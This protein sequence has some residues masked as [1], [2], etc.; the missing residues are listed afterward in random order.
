MSL[1]VADMV[2]V[3]AAMAGCN[4]TPP[5]DTTIAKAPT[6]AVAKLRRL[7]AAAVPLGENAPEIIANHDA[8]YG[9]EQALIQA[10][11]DCLGKREAREDTAAQQ[12]QH[13]LIMRRFRRAVEESPDQPLYIAEICE[14][15]GVSDRTL[16]ACC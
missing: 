4:L 9:L 11:V 1:P 12:R 16:R 8:A 10:V 13:E 3:G 5:R 7:H 15:I 14:A 6:D 2:S